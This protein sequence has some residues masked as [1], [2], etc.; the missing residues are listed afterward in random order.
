[1]RTLRYEEYKTEE[2]INANGRKTY[3]C[4]LLWRGLRIPLNSNSNESCH[5]FVEDD[6]LYIFKRACNPWAAEV[7]MYN[8]YTG[9][10]IFTLSLPD[11]NSLSIIRNWGWINDIN[12]CKRMVVYANLKADSSGYNKPYTQQGAS[13][14]CPTNGTQWLA[15]YPF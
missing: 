9:D 12:F 6:I 14:G 4:A 13:N 3:S 15:T 1:M 11:I 7:T 10:K 2:G 5:F 8:K